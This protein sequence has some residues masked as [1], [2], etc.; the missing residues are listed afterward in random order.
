MDHFTSWALSLLSCC[1]PRFPFWV[2]SEGQMNESHRCL[3]GALLRPRYQSPAPGR[4]TKEEWK[5]AASFFLPPFQIPSL[6]FLQTYRLVQ[7]T[8]FPQAAKI[9]GAGAATSSEVEWIPHHSVL[10]IP[11][12]GKPATAFSREGGF[13]T[14][15]EINDSCGVNRRA[16]REQGSPS[17]CAAKLGS[18]LW[19]RLGR[20]ALV[21]HQPAP[22]AKH[23]QDS[24]PPR[25]T[26]PK[27]GRSAHTVSSTRASLGSLPWDSQAAVPNL[28]PIGRQQR[29]ENGFQFSL[30]MGLDSSALA[31]SFKSNFRSKII[32]KV[33]LHVSLRF[34]HKHR[35]HPSGLSKA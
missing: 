19:A 10:I 17:L 35:T 12:L 23:S 29:Y 22:H 28:H 1:S 20:S 30:V 8:L 32:L 6:P 18:S 27:L 31:F 2:V 9:A 4:G 25:S 3:E 15:R 24:R 5:A 11:A 21:P 34:F 33:H 26:L 14:R 13:P 7:N 16:S